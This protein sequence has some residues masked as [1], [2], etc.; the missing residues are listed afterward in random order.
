T[1]NWL[2]A[3]LPDLRSPQLLFGQLVSEHKSLERIFL[4][5]PALLSDVLTLAAWS[6]LLATTIENNPDYVIWLQRERAITRV[7]TGEELSEALGSFSLINSQPDPHAMLARFR[8]RD[9]L[10]PHLH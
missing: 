2:L 1:V 7:R 6:P 4:R 8:R 10:P 9:F 3:Q 5:D